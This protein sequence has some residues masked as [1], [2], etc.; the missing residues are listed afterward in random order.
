MPEQYAR[1]RFGGR[2]DG[3]RLRTISPVFQLSP[4]SVPDT[5][6]AA[7]SFEDSVDVA[8][9]E[10]WLRTRRREGDEN[11]SLLHLVIA[12]YVRTLALRPAMNRFVSGRFIYARDTIDVV[13][14]SGGTGA[15]DAGAMNVTVRFLPTDTVYDVYRKINARVDN[16]KADQ[17]A[18]RTERLAATLVKTPRF[19][20]RFAMSV[21]RWLDY[22]GWL[23]EGM[24]ERSAY[25]G[26][27]AIS[28]EGA[29]HLPPVRRSLNSLGNLP[30]SLSVGRIRTGLEIDKAGQLAERKFM[31]FAVTYD[32]RIADSAYIGSAFRYFRYYLANPDAL[33]TPPERMNEDA[34]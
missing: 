28:D 27:A 10:A 17:T 19:V 25:H 16:L 13:L 6:D 12:A 20:L 2:K 4:F 11:M 33:E 26:S 24:M 23:S 18:D 30:V 21:L 34:L 31:D 15:S 1:R 9:I 5:S 22:H 8:P 7:S 3:R 32:S 14:T 29:F